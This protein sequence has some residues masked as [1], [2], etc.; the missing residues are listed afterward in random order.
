MN[1][2]EYRPIINSVTDVPNDN[3]G[4][5]YIN[6]SKSYFDNNEIR[7][8]E[9]YH[10]E[11]LTD[12][13]WI[14]VGSSAAYGS[15]NYTVQAMTEIDSSS[16]NLGLTFFRVVASMDE[17]LWISEIDSGYS[18]NNNYLDTKDTSIITKSFSLSQNYPN[19][20]NPI[21]T[22]NYNLPEESIVKITIY[23]LMGNIVKEIVNQ[24]E[25]SGFKS[26]QWN[27]TNNKGLPVSAGAYIYGIET[28][29]FRQ[30]RK[31]V[32]LK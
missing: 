16:I 7:N 31:M 14:S 19:P 32:L 23:D 8:T 28:S 5:V 29:N 1:I 20:F 27:G 12:G 9:I 22:L 15:E 13:D 26:V 24:V 4:W 11:R 6:F 18:I 17:G 21:T 30:T 10:I 2:V 25:T 3:G